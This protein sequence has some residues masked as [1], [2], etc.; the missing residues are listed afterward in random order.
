MGR[1]WKTFCFVGGILFASQVVC[2]AE[3]ITMVEEDW[4]LILNAPNATISTPQL[5]LAISPVANCNSLYATFE[6]NKRSI[7]TKAGGLQIQMWNG[8]NLA[9]GG[10]SV[11]TCA[12][13]NSLYVT[14]EKLLWT[15]RMSVDNKGVLTIT[16]LNGT[17]QSWGKFGNSVELTVSAAS[18]LND[19][20]AYDPNVSAAN[21]GVDFGGAQVGKLILRKVR[22]YSNGKKNIDR[23][24]DRV[25]Y[26]N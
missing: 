19:L 9:S 20:N 8:D 23:A 14:G 5:T 6:I 17:S 4:E 13:T 3:V 26:P 15:Q 18:S 2:Y 7:D 25:V 21:S 10:T 12:I 1:H 24:L 16:V 11:S 22:T